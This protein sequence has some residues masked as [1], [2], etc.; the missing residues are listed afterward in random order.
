MQ[1]SHG[2]IDVRQVTCVQ[3]NIIRDGK[4]GVTG[5]LGGEDGSGLLGGIPIA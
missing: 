3:Q 4:P 1:A 5:G 2:G